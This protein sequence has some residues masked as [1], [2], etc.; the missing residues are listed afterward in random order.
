MSD[1]R[2][3]SI[4]SGI[5]KGLDRA[6]KNYQTAAANMTNLQAARYRLQKDRE[7]FDQTKKINE[8]KLK[9]LEQELDPATLA[10]EK[11]KLANQTALAKA[12]FT[13]YESKSKQAEQEAMEAMEAASM[14]KDLWEKLL[15][16][17]LDPRISFEYGGI[18]VGKQG[19]DD[20]EGLSTDKAISYLNTKNKNR[21]PSD[22]EP[23][24]EIE[25][26]VK[27]ILE[28]RLGSASGTT[29]TSG[30]P[31]FPKWAKGKE[32]EYKAAKDAGYTDEE[33]KSYMRA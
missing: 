3:L 30:G 21:F 31:S 16:G 8:M 4:F 5:A 33:I 12:Q 6:T 13:L 29:T 18:K 28:K 2:R 9:Q 15:A 1:E 17:T 25:A 11:E 20:E 7:T 27:D 23:E 26:M 24:D 19:E 14:K 10:L 22:D 32:R